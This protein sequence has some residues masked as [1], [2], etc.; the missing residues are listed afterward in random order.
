MQDL[1]VPID[2]GLINTW[3]RPADAGSPTVVL[4]HGLTGTSR[5]WIP[6][7]SHL[8]A[9]LG[10]LAIDARGRGQS[11]QA[12]PPYGLATIADDVAR[13]LD[14]LGVETATVAGY[15]MGAWIAALLAVNH[16]DRIDRVVLVDGSLPIETDPGLTAEEI[17]TRAVGPA[18][19]RLSMGFQSMTAYFG[20]W[21]DHPAFIDA[22]HPQLEDVFSY[23]VHD[24]DGVI[25]AR[26]N[27]DAVI[28]GG[29]DFA[30][31]AAANNA[32]RSIAVPTTL[33][34]VDHGLLGQPGGFMSEAAAATAGKDNPNIGVQMLDGLNHYTLILGDGAPRVAATISVGST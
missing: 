25:E 2:D 14:H 11:W 12:P 9:E 32:H 31:D 21:Q 19:A 24:V 30:L 1:L 3:H 13:S 5:W 8:P 29:S 17:V 6:V 23:D 34:I 15:S 4:I 10:L 27:T 18:V 7:I 16:P 33:L 22:W 20:F 26:A 28:A